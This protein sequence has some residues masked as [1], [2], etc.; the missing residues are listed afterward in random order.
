MTNSKQP[1]WLDRAW[2][3]LGV[4]EAAG[5]ANDARVLAYYRD[6]GHPEIASD[7]VAW[8]AAFVGACLD[9][10]GITSSGSLLARSYLTWGEAAGDDCIGAIAVFSRGTDQ[11]QGHV[12]FLVGTA[13]DNLVI[14]GGNQSDAVSVEFFPRDRLLGLRWPSSTD[15]SSRPVQST[16]DRALDHVFE[17]EGGFTD[18]PYDPGGPTNLGITLAT[19]AAHKRA[20]LTAA[21]TAGLR[22]ELQHLDKDTAREIYLARYWQPSRS[23]LLPPAVAV[24]HFDA[25]VN[26]GVGG[27]ARMLQ[28]ALEVDIDGDIGPVTLAAAREQPLAS[29][30]DRYAAIRHAR[31]QGLP[32]FW[33]FGRGWTRR[34]EATRALATT[35]LDCPLP[36]LP[37]SKQKEPP[38]TTD[39]GT[40]ADTNAA[41]PKWWGNSMTIWGA[42]VTG[43]TNVLPVVGPLLGI[44]ISAEMIRDLGE[45]ATR[46]IQAI[47]GIVGILLTVFGRMR[48]VQPIARRDF[49]VKF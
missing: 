47:G 33:R 42:I 21:N 14:L 41:E 29:T 6:A 27:S 28:E 34:V 35:L 19:Y 23:G 22:Q 40:N 13:E 17:M 48:A 3:D 31:Y 32:H 10:S 5:P 49:N 26:H 8:C 7:S 12:G 46:A 45:H 36:P 43:L 16:F 20:T 44:D 9:R 15:A 30:L 39:T 18:D 11:T 37:T 24:M 4:H 38:M 25:S 1:A 2:A